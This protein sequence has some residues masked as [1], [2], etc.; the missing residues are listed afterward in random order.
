[1]EDSNKQRSGN[2]SSLMDFEPM[3]PR[4]F[5]SPGSPEH[6]EH[7]KHKKKK[8]VQVEEEPVD[9]DSD[10]NEVTFFHDFIAGGLAGSASVVVGHPF[11][12]IKVRFQTSNM[13]IMQ[14]MAEFGGVSSLF[15]GMAAPLSAAAAINA[16]VFSSYGA[17]SRF[18]DNYIGDPD[19]YA[20]LP[21]DPWYKSSVCGSF[22]GLMQCFVICPMEHVKCRLQVQPKKGTKGGTSNYRGPAQAARS[23]VRQHGFTKLYQGWWTTCWRELPA[24]ALYFATYDYLKDA[25]NTYLSRQ[26]GVE[27]VDPTGMQHTHTWFASAFAGG[28]AGSLTWGMVYPIDVIKTRI[29]TAPLTTPSSELSII[30]VGRQIIAQHGW[31]YLFRGLSITLVRAFPVNGTI[32]P[33]YEFTI[34]QMSKWQI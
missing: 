21:H 16:I 33:V 27:D 4:M 5:F 2:L 1:M 28:C 17:S 20:D 32:F 26:M 34:H 3:T 9:S 22:A 7:P 18:Y 13:G 15:R 23:I 30:H 14:S 29:Q 6:V 10:P 31:R 25:T 8:P 11:D 12:T 19:S 24:F